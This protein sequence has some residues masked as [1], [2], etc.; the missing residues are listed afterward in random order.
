MFFGRE[1]LIKHALFVYNYQRLDSITVVYDGQTRL[2]HCDE[3]Y[4]YFATPMYLHEPNR[5]PWYLGQICASLRANF[6]SMS[7]NFW[8]KLDIDLN[9]MNEIS[10]FLCY[11]TF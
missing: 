6:N 2:G 8:N 3:I 10:C 7:S 11:V 4:G 5:F 1:R 9:V